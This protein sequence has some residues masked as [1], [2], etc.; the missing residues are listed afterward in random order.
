MKF[1]R[2][3]K[4]TKSFH[5]RMLQVFAGIVV[6]DEFSKWRILFFGPLQMMSFQYFKS[7]Q[8]YAYVARFFSS[9]LFMSICVTKTNNHFTKK[10]LTQSTIHTTPF[11]C[12]N[13]PFYIQCS[14]CLDFIVVSVCVCVCMYVCR[15]LG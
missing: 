9:L 14:F 13:H 11:D 4:S 1:L 8:S 6:V 5:T 12:L 10:M 2:I 15:S 7:Q 3:F